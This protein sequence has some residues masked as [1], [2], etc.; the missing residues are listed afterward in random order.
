MIDPYGPLGLEPRLDAKPWGGRRLAQFGFSLP[1]NELIGEAVVTATE[2]T[3]RTGPMA[4]RQLGHLVKEDPWALIGSRGLRATGGRTVFPLLV[5]FIDAAA[6]LSIQVHPDDAS[7]ALHRNTLGKTEAWHVLAAEPDAALYLGLRPDASPV[8]FEVAC[9]EA[10]GKGAAMLGQLPAVSGQSVLIPA[11]TVHAL[12]QGVLV[13]EIQQASDMTFRLDD[14]G[15]VDANGQARSL[16]L[17]DGFAVLEPS[18]RPEV[19]SPVDLGGHTQRHI[20]A[21]CRYFALERVVLSRGMSFESYAPDTPQVMTC[22]DGVV[23]LATA[24]GMVTL[25]AGETA[26]VP[27]V[28]SR[29]C[30]QTTATGT[31]L[32]AWVPDLAADIIRPADAAGATAEEMT[33]LAGPLPDLRDMTLAATA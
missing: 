19:I 2:A 30:L 16:H 29:S 3:V 20:L 27:A 8:G 12:G 25:R 11:G 13:Y 7:A 21:A 32:R 17:D 6:N 9:R 26:V 1:P 33:C 10:S 18:F 28:T 31:V 24:G 23:D 15:R 4:G 14:W 5:K 22:L